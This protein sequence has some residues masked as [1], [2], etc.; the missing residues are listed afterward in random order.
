MRE[1]IPPLPQY[2]F[3]AWYSSQKKH[4]DNFTI[5]AKYV[6]IIVSLT[7]QAIILDIFTIKNYITR[8]HA[9][10]KTKGG[11]RKVIYKSVSK[12]FRTE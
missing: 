5:L 1:D 6:Y 10:T 2:A 3:M 4:R 9:Y 11:K 8:Y 12:S 7:I